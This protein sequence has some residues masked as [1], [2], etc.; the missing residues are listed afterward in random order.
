MLFTRGSLSQSHH[1]QRLL[2]LKDHSQRWRT[3]N[4]QLILHNLAPLILKQQ[5]L[6]QMVK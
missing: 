5:P 4:D 1:Q 6:S 3:F 2:V